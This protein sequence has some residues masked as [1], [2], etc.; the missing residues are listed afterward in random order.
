[1]RVGVAIASRGRPN[2]I[3]DIL[4][5]LARQSVLPHKIVLAVTASAD[6]PERL[7]DARTDVI[8]GRAGL[9]I[10]RN[11]ALDALAADSD[12]IVFY[13][14]DFLPSRYSIEGIQRLFEGYPHVAAATGT[15]L[16]D[17]IKKGGIPLA[18]ALRIVEEF[19]AISSHVP[20]VKW[21]SSTYGCNMAYRVSAITDMR[22]DERLPLYGWQEDLDFSARVRERGDVVITNLFAGVHRGVTSGRSPGRA[23]GYS[24]IVNPAY[25]AIKGTM[26]PSYAMKLMLKNL[27]ANHFRAVFPEPH[28]DRFGRARGNWAGIYDILKGTPKPE[29]ILRF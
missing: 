8:I 22:F 26:A 7:F 24:Q 15:V 28:I 21:V 16:D 2:E 5:C 13:D 9:C 27:I 1:M 17:G 10:Q 3:A 11:R 18:R 20:Q 25:L 29:N 14:D 6:L 12:V 23:L 4:D 19:D